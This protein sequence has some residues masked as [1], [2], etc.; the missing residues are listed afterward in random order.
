MEA[1]LIENQMKFNDSVSETLKFQEEQIKSLTTICE[2]LYEQTKSNAKLIAEIGEK[3]VT[4]SR[5]YY[6]IPE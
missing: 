2:C 5:D 1:R 6:G 3:F 4:L